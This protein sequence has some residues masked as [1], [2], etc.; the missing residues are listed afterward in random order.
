MET[1]CFNTDAR[2]RDRGSCRLD[3][4][5]YSIVELGG[6]DKMGDNAWYL[7]LLGDMYR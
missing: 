3:H 7:T 1:L 5:N 2:R 4:N 6:I